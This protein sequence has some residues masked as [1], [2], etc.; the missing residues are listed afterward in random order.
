MT[1]R[2]QQVS[3]QSAP[4]TPE[5][6]M[7]VLIMILASAAGSFDA[8]SYLGLG[9]VFPANMTGKTALLGLRAGEG[10]TAAAARAVA[11]LVGFALGVAV[12]A[13]LVERRQRNAEWPPAVSEALVLET[14]VLAV[15]AIFWVRTGANPSGVRLGLLIL[16]AAAAMGIQSEAVRRLGVRGVTTTYITG[17]LTT[18]TSG[19][20]RWARAAAEGKT[21]PDPAPGLPLQAAVWG[22]YV[23]GAAAGGAAHGRWEGGAVLLPLAAVAV[24]TVIAVVR[25]RIHRKA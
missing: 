8:I 1:V 22:I 15:V 10:N 5:S 16:P 12:C 4:P 3:E 19:M 17:T 13:A 25:Y 9:K 6:P 24:V 23:I 2:E 20:V 14:V 7:G 11:A 21:T 18:L